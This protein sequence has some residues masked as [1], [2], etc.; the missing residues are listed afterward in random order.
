MI[1]PRCG[2]ANQATSANCARCAGSLAPPPPRDPSP[3][4][5]VLP[6]TRRAELELGRAGAAAPG[7][8]TGVPSSPAE[9]VAELYLLAADHATGQPPPPEAPQGP[10]SARPDRP[11]RLAVGLS[12]A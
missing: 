2:S 10:G 7:G 1:C 12:G 11:G 8:T 4:P 5:L 3:L 9:P 6:M